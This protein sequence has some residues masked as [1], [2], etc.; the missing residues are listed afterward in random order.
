MLTL[1]DVDGREHELPSDGRYVDAGALAATTGWTV[2]PVGLCR[3]EVC[4]PLFGRTVTAPT[5]DGWVDLQEWAEA[6]DLLVAHDEGG[7]V[8]AVTPSAGARAREVADGRAPSLTLP[9]VDG[10]PVSF[11][12]FS[13]S[14]R[15]LVTWASWCGCRHELGGWQKLQDELADTGLKIFSVALDHDAEDSRPWIEAARPTYPVAVDT[16]HVTAERYGIT[17]VPSV[18][19]VDEDDAIVK[20]PTIAPGDDQFR[21][22][23]EIDSEQH[24]DLLRAWVRDGDLPASAATAPAARTDAE[25][26][27][28]AER[29]VAAHLQRHG[30]TDAARAHLAAAQELAPWDWTVRRG[31]IA[32]TG[33]DP[34]LG[35]EFTSFWEEWD[36]G[37]RPGYTPTT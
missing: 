1:I 4:V 22:F 35:E 12:D 3:G 14:K 25:Q 15:V 21:E 7:R 27:A 34:F 11:D 32:M 10:N 18:V 8:V 9:D 19:W 6:L 26:Q 31:G 2:K 23:T 29:R 28:L 33:G 30:R 5:D 17:N 16:A 13:G 20:P 37:G 24:H 36:A